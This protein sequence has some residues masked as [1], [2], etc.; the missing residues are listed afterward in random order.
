MNLDTDE[1]LDIQN[2]VFSPYGLKIKKVVHGERGGALRRRA[3]SPLVPGA[4]G[5]A[6]QIQAAGSYRSQSSSRVS[7]SYAS[8][9]EAET[10]SQTQRLVPKPGLTDRLMDSERKEALYREVS[11]KLLEGARTQTP[12]SAPAG[13]PVSESGPRVSESGERVEGPRPVVETL[14]YR[15]TVRSGQRVYHPGNLV[16]LGDVNPGGLVQ[17]GGDIVVM[18]ALRGVAHA[19]A[20]GDVDSAIYALKLEPTQIRIAN[21]IGRPPEGEERGPWKGPETARLKDGAIIIEAMDNTR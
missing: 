2:A 19:G 17:A 1:I 7:E 21:V 12:A 6:S 18:G 8:G 15:G 3:S 14:L 16:I 20:G 9:S 11:R 4:L 13:R 5:S 10:N